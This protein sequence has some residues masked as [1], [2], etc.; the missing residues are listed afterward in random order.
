MQRLCGL[1][2]PDFIA[3]IWCIHRKS[4]CIY[5][6]V[7]IF[8]GGNESVRDDIIYKVMSTPDYKVG[9]ATFLVVA[10]I[11]L[12]KVT[13][14]EDRYTWGW[15]CNDASAPLGI[16]SYWHNANKG[17]GVENGWTCYRMFPSQQEDRIWFIS[18]L[19]EILIK[20]QRK[21]CQNIYT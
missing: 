21:K 18:N 7:L 1:F 15:I 13:C 2:L 5:N 9:N 10:Q 14:C 11:S 8:K 19:L 17:G 20:L 3:I 16:Y 12:H 4:I 6:I